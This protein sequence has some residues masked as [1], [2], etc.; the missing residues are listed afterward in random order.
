MNGIVALDR[1]R[2]IRHRH[3]VLDNVSLSIGRGDCLALIGANGSGKTT[4]LRM[5]MGFLKPVSGT[6]SLFGESP[7]DFRPFR[8][9]IGY[10][11][12]ALS[13][14]YKT[15]ISVRDVVSIGRFG[16]AGPCRRL[17]GE[18]H[19]I[20]ETAIEDVGI[21]HL[22]DRPIGHL[23][24][25]EYQKVQFA[26]AVSQT[27]DLL[28]LDEPTSSLD[29]GAQRDC[30]DLIVKLHTRHNLTTVIVMHDLK[31]LP[32]HCNRAVII[33]NAQVAYDGTFSGV[34]TEKNLAHVYKRQPS[35]VLRELA[36]ELMTKGGVP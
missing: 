28:L 13:V 15:P 1:I 10:V 34:F 4:I 35:V 6:L 23:S 30:L 17:S 3:L 33:D 20:V 12:Q 8:T 2:L 16:I 18:D 29:L 32:T 11:P 21:A 19:R 36:A 9:R 26:R 7:K 25:G 22:A 14:D 31:S 5:I 27:P 24:G